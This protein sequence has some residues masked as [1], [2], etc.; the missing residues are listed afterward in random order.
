M[1]EPGLSDMLAVAMDTARAAGQSTLKFFGND[2]D[3]SI[4]SD[5]SPVTRADIESE[6]IIRREITRHFPRHAILGEESGETAGT[7]AHIRW[8]ID[9][10][11]GT[12]SFIRGV[13]MYGVLVGVEVDGRPSVG[14]V[15][16]P[17]TDEM[18]AA[19]TGLGCTHNGQR[20]HVSTINR[21]EDATIVTTNPARCGARWDGYLPLTRSALLSAG[22]GDAYGHVM[23]ATG[24]ADIMLDPR[25]SPWDVAALVPILRESG[26]QITSWA[27]FETING[28]DA[29]STNG[30]LHRTILAALRDARPDGDHIR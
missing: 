1:S 24:R 23:V 17:A 21:V 30:H 10:L 3:V 13:P 4:K 16:L 14:A 15:Y 12:K 7:N 8:I 20:R 11:D 25:C 18:I 2:L 29:V 28:G 6:S 5:G 26:G 19:A 22:W 27:G 9:P